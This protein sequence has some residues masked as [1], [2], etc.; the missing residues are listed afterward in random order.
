MRTIPLAQGRHAFGRE[1]EQY[2]AGRPG[3]PARLFDII[4]E[5]C[6]IR[7]GARAFE[8]G[9]G[10]GQVTRTLLEMELSKLTAIEPDQRL[11]DFLAGACGPQQA[12]RLEIVASTFEEAGLPAASF[13]FG[14]AATSFHWLKAG[15]ALDKVMRLLR[16]GGW[17]MA[18]WNVFADPFSEDPFLNATQPIFERLERTPGFGDGTQ[19]PFGLDT[20]RRTAELQ[21]AGLVNVSSEVVHRTVTMRTGEI[22]ALY[23][24]FSQIARRTQAE[25]DAIERELRQICAD[26]GGRVQRTFLTPVY[27]AQKPFA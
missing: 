2:A 3:Y 23:A 27:W 16:P 14:I 1:P 26:F 20:A 8:I 13:D 19:L 21:A 4:R 18:C 7:E 12:A 22:V 25:R 11:C 24:T 5:Q 10:T 9:P 6:G 15:E 17:W